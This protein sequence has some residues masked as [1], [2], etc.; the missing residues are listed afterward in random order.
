M[1]ESPVLAPIHRR[2]LLFT[3]TACCLL[4]FTAY[5]AGPDLRPVCLPLVIRLAAKKPIPTAF[6]CSPE[7]RPK[8]TTGRNL[9]LAIRRSTVP[10]R[11]HDISPEASSE[12][13]IWQAAMAGL[14]G[15]RNRRCPLLFT[16]TDLSLCIVHFFAAAPRICC[17]V[18]VLDCMKSYWTNISGL[19]A[20]A[21]RSISL[22]AHAATARARFTDPDRARDRSP[23]HSAPRA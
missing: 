4:F 7:K 16:R 1:E 5:S 9:H 6:P 18:R 15:H 17:P 11:T 14:T 10:G 19:R 13:R 23:P 3:R 2:P 22:S 8:R 21:G 20:I 12:Y